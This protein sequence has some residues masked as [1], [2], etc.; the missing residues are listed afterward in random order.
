MKISKAHCN[1]H[2]VK[3]RK[4][5]EKNLHSIVVVFCDHRTKRKT[6]SVIVNLNDKSDA[7]DDEIVG[8]FG[9]LPVRTYV[10]FLCTFLM[11]GYS[12]CFNVF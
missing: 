3:Y 4:I 5:K 2:L 12:T 11:Y 9:H 1:N 10:H 8:N 6:S 7:Y